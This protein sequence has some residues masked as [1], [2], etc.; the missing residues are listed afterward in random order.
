MSAAATKATAHFCVE[1]AASKLSEA[2]ERIEAARQAMAH[3]EGPGSSDQYDELGVLA[4]T[5]ERARFRLA[6]WHSRVGD[7]LDLD[8]NTRA[9]LANSQTNVNTGDKP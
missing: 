7:Q 2:Y 5:I 4:R 8:S 1:D 3:V 9:A 6:A